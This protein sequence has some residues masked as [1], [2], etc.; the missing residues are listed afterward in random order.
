MLERCDRYAVVLDQDVD[1]RPGAA[2][3]ESVDHGCVD[4]D[5]GAQRPGSMMS[6]DAAGV[7]PSAVD[8][9]GGPTIL[10]TFTVIAALLPMAFVSGLMGP[11]MSPIPINASLGML[12]SLVVAFVFTPWMSNRMLASVARKFEAHTHEH[13]SGSPALERFFDRIMSPFLVGVKGYRNRWKLL[14]GVVGLIVLSL[15][16]VVGVRREG[17]TA[18]GAVA[19]AAGLLV[20]GAATWGGLQHQWHPVGVV[21]DHAISLRDAASLEG[22]PRSELPVGTEVRVDRHYAGFLLVEDGR[23]RRGWLPDGA[24]LLPSA[25]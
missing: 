3:L 23:G 24:V 7:D 18:P 1:D 14:A 20:G 16:L 4:V 22:R 9:V 15:L 5:G 21:V 10:A 6:D 19:L 11:Y 2:A 25:Q 12:I 8:E 13:E 17:L